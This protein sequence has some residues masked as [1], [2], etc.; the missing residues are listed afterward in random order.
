M[1]GLGPQKKTAGYAEEKER[2]GM[3]VSFLKHKKLKR[4]KK[5]ET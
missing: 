2:W 4:T 3:T 1:F 5:D